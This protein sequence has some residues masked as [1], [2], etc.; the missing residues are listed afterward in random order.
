MG[1]QMTQGRV[2]A[3]AIPADSNAVIFNETAI[4]QMGLKNPIGTTVKLWGSPKTIIGVTRDFHY[5]SLYKNIGPLFICFSKNNQN[6]I[7]R[8]SAKAEKETIA[9]IGALYGKYNRGLPFEYKFLDED[10]RVLYAAEQR[11][12]VLSEWFAGIAI[13]ISC[14]GL[15]GLSAFVVQRRRKEISI[16]KVVGASVSR[17]ATMLSV[18]FIRLVLMA[19]LVAVPLAWY[20][21]GRWLQTFAYHI[22]LDAATF[23]VPG[24]VVTIA[25]VSFQTI[26]GAFANPADNLR[27]E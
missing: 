16:R 22:A 3:A 12:S 9:K 17:L 20:A 4:R 1:V 19:F 6:I 26:K 8:I 15:F 2:F 18:D 10:Y 23:L 25:T 7:A 27:S 11:V 24:I 5:E 13:L 14:L 21:L